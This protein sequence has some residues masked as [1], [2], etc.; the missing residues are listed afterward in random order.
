M[1]QRALNVLFVCE[2]N[3]IRS[4]MAEA[5][6]NRFGDGRFRAFS[7]D[8]EPAATVHPLTLEM[9]QTGGLPTAH[10]KARSVREFMT[11]TAPKMDFVI[12][13]GAK[14]LTTAVRGLPGHPMLVQWGIS[15]PVIPGDIAAQRFAFRRAFREL[16]NR[17]RLFV[18][19]QQ[20]REPERSYGEPQQ[21]QNA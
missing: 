7:A 13:M 15:E 6:L 2:R 19:V 5:L 21:A 10:L 20:R 17:I 14:D 16:E 11:P 4:I 1:A 9:L 12:L 3:S 8:L 18:L